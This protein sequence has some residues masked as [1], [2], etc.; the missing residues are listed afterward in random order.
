MHRIARSVALGFVVFLTL[1]GS[2][3]AQT[4]QDSLLV[5]RDCK[6]VEQILKTGEPAAQRQWA[7][8]RLPVC[9]R[10]GAQFLVDAIDAVHGS[11]DTAYIYTIVNAVAFV[12]DARVWQSALS[13]VGDAGATVDARIG[14]LEMLLL[15][16]TPGRII[17]RAKFRTPGPLYACG[18]SQVITDLLPVVGADLPPSHLAVGISAANAVASQT[19]DGTPIHRAATCTAYT[20]SF[21]ADTTS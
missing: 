6:R 17:D 1:A 7:V 10:N 9:G 11:G 8:T 5:R 21:L 15:I 14:G 18:A 19:I 12:R 3:S 13:L 4:S 2:A 20:L 16:E